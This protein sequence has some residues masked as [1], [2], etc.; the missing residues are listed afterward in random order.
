MLAPISSEKLWDWHRAFDISSSMALFVGETPSVGSL[1]VIVNVYSS[2]FVN[3]L[4]RFSWL[5][6]FAVAEKFKLPTLG[7][8]AFL[9]VI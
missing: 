3:I 1:K 5:K 6:L 4:L 8:C 2:S 9:S 7:N